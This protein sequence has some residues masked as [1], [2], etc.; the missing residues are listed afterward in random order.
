MGT[1]S[2]GS[3]SLFYQLVKFNNKAKS[4][5]R[6]F[7]FMLRNTFHSQSIWLGDV[8][9]KGSYGIFFLNGNYII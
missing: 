4:I 2:Y 1:S 9:L 7:L 8:M 6:I 3:I 5:T